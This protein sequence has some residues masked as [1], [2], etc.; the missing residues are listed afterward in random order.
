MPNFAFQCG[1]TAT[2]DRLD[3]WA[4]GFVSVSSRPVV[5]R[6]SVAGQRQSGIGLSVSDRPAIMV[7][8]YTMVEDLYSE[9]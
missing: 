7:I 2:F 9:I 6:F 8:E 3:M 4:N 1:R 5:V